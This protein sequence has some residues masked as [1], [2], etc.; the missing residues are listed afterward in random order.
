M[1]RVL[2]HVGKGDLAWLTNNSDSDLN[3]ESEV[4]STYSDSD[5]DNS[6]RGSNAGAK[7]RVAP[8]MKTTFVQHVKIVS[9]DH[10]RDYQSLQLSLGRKL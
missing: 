5:A 7:G 2:S 8:G 9:R 6:V 3:Y 4:L 1:V 10:R